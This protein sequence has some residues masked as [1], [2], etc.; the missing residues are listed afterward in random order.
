MK[1]RETIN[2]HKEWVAPPKPK[3]IVVIIECKICE[4]RWICEKDDRKTCP[5]CNYR[6]WEHKI[7]LEVLTEVEFG[8]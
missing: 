6:S 5:E 7:L 3:M 4:N 8:D 2:D 1:E